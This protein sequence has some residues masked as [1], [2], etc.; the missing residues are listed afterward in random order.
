M[1]AMIL[2]AG[3]GTRMRP[4]TDS[5]PKPLLRVADKPL[6][7]H[8]VEQ[9]AGCGFRQL[10]VNLAYRG[11]QIADYLG[12]GRAWGVDI[13]YSREPYPLETG[14][15]LL[16]ALPMLSSDEEAFLV[17]NGDIWSDFDYRTLAQAPE[18]LAHLVMVANPDHHRDGDFILEHGKLIDDRSRMAERLTYSGIAVLR[19]GLLRGQQQEVFP[20]AP[21]LRQ[22]MARGLVS[23]C[24]HQGYWLDVGTPE[25]LQQLDNYLRSA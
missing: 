18:G 24:L 3:L 25:R 16:R 7:Q 23:G 15:G 5:C 2:A 1:K 6:I 12:D 8:H 19:P 13:V 10:V 9:L 22:A 11:E 14:G 4:L 21:L 17:V 20:L